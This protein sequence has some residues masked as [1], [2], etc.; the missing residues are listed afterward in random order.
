MADKSEFHC[1]I[2][3]LFI[4]NTLDY[5]PIVGIYAEAISRKFGFDA[6]TS[7]SI[8]LSLV[9]TMKIS[10]KHSVEEHELTEVEMSFERTAEGIR[11]T[12]LEKG[13]PMGKFQIL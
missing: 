3:R 1:E 7:S 11:I 10:I 6:A 8:A 13:L 9:D 2:S 5:A 4:P 12:I